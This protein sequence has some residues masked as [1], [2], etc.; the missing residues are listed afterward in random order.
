MT[1]REAGAMCFEIKDGIEACKNKAQLI[2]D[3]CRELE[4]EEREALGDIL[5]SLRDALS[6]MQEDV[7]DE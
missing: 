5:E 7:D 1:S 4:D 6:L 3:E 2:L